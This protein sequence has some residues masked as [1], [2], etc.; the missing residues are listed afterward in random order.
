MQSEEPLPLQSNI[1]YF[2]DKILRLIANNLSGFNKS[3]IYFVPL[4]SFTT[5]NTKGRRNKNITEGGKDEATTTTG[6]VAGQWD[7]KVDRGRT[8][9][10]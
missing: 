7:S 9:K 4:H 10:H 1:S 2:I 5:L 6:R 8:G 3:A